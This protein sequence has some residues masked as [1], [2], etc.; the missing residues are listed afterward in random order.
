M[1]QHLI[2]IQLEKKKYSLLQ[3]ALTQEEGLT[4]IIAEHE[5]EVIAEFADTLVLLD[6][7]KINEVGT[8]QDIFPRFVDH[9]EDI[10]VRVPQVTDLASRKTENFSSIP[11]TLDESVGMYKK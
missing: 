10:G 11:V 5:V 3:E 9:Q 6:E 2:S 8:P 7:G 1:N 4:V